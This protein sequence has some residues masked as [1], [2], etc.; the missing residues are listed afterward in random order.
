MCQKS[1]A[2]KQF[3][4]GSHRGNPS[5]QQGIELWPEITLCSAE[6]SLSSGSVAGVP[7][8]GVITISNH[9]TIM[10]LFARLKLFLECC[11]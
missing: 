11:W 9:V 8:Q 10:R 7:G 2:G 1:V 5:E 6:V 4:P 3:K